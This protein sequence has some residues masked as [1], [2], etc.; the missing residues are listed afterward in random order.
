[1]PVEKKGTGKVRVCVNFRKLNRATPKNEYPMSVAEL[2]VN[3]ASGHKIISFLDG[4]AGYNQ[5]FMA[6]RM[7]TKWHFGE[8][9][10][11]GCLS[12]S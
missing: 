3:S 9:G 2:L 12:G 6:K 5:I 1:V 4:N 10:S 7:Y 8:L 11:S